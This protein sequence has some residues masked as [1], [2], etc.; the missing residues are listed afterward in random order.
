MISKTPKRP[1][2]I[3]RE[4]N[5]VLP[6]GVLSTPEQVIMYY[7]NC[8]IISGNSV[9]IE[10]I[11][12]SNSNIDLVFEDLG[13]ND[14]YIRRKDGGRFE[15]GINKRHHSNRQKFSMAHEYAHYLLHRDKIASMSIGE[16]ILYRDDSRNI[17]EWEANSFAAELLMPEDLVSSAFVIG[18]GN[19][20]KMADILQVSQDALRYRLAVL[21]YNIA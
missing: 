6:P 3:T 4:N 2:N 16:Q 9:D 15:I 17:V 10:E 1:G 11:I 21:E 13:V 5:I 18:S 8:G 20:K 14:A 19:L 12:L 7:Q